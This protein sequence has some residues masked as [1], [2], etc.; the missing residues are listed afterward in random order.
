MAIS[1]GCSSSSGDGGSTSSPTDTPSP[2]RTDDPTATTPAQ[3]ATETPAPAEFEIVTVASPGQ[4][5]VAERHSVEITVLNRGG[6][7]G[8]FEG[9]VEVTTRQVT[10]WEE[11]GTIEIQDV[12]PGETATYTI[13]G[14]SFDQTYQLVFRLPEYDVEWAYNVVAPQPDITTGET[15]L[16]QVDAGY[17]TRPMAGVLVTNEGE[18]PTKRFSVSADWLDSNGDYL[19]TSEAD[20]QTLRTGETWSAR[21]D[22]LIDIDNYTDIGDFEVSVGNVEPATTLDPEGVALTDEQFRASESQVIV[23]GGV[24]ND[25]DSMLDYIEVVAKVYDADGNVVGWERTNELEIEAGGTLRFD[26]EPDT[27][28]RNER[29]ESYE[30]VLSDSTLSL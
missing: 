21:I 25:R 6:K 9:T 30:I 18:S 5:N 1:A 20:I 11:A 15:S 3:T 27:K 16:L 23:R 19:A 22:P 24:Q 29:V 26:L 14:L 12:Q 4:V 13:S 10:T 17:E 8:D 2:D 7:T 28:G